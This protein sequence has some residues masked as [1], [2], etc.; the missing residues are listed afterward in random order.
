[1][2]DAMSMSEREKLSSFLFDRSDREIL[3]IKFL[4]GTD[5]NLTAGELCETAAGVL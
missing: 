3:D 5:P 2:E 4:S 1:M